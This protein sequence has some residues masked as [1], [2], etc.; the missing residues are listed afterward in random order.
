MVMA[1]ELY[2]GIAEHEFC[3]YG[4]VA[5]KKLQ[6]FVD[7]RRSMT[8]ESYR[9]F[10]EHAYRQFLDHEAFQH[11]T[12]SGAKARVIGTNI[13][14]CSNKL[15]GYVWYHHGGISRRIPKDVAQGAN[16]ILDDEEDEQMA[17]EQ[18]DVKVP[19]EM[20]ALDI[21]ISI[22]SEE[23]ARVE[24][25][26][27]DPFN[28]M[29]VDYDPDDVTD[30]YSV[31]PETAEVTSD[32]SK[33]ATSATHTGT[34][35]Q[36]TL[37]S[38]TTPQPSDEPIYKGIQDMEKEK[39]KSISMETEDDLLVDV[40]IQ[41]FNMLS[42]NQKSRVKKTMEVKV[43]LLE[44][45]SLQQE[46]SKQ[47]NLFVPPPEPKQEEAKESS[48]KGEE[49]KASSSKGEEAKESVEFYKDYNITGNEHGSVLRK[50][51][52]LCSP[53]TCN[54]WCGFYNQGFP[55]YPEHKHMFWHK[56]YRSI[57]PHRTPHKHHWHTETEEFLLEQY[58][59]THQGEHL[60]ST[61]P[62]LA[63]LLKYGCSDPRL[64][65]R[66][67]KEVTRRTVTARKKLEDD[68]QF[69]C[70]I[71][72][73]HLREN[74]KISYAAVCM[75]L[76]GAYLGAGVM[77]DRDPIYPGRSSRQLSVSF[78]NLG[79][80]CRKIFERL[81]LPPQLEK[82]RNYMDSEIDENF[83][84]IGEKP[85]YNNF[86]INVV[87][88]LG[89][90]IFLNCEA[91]SIY[92]YGERLIEG[93]YALCFN[94]WKNLMRAAR[95]GKDRYV[96]QIAGYKE[97]EKDT[98]R[99]Y[100]SWAIFEVCFGKTLDRA[101]EEQPL[102]RGKL[103]V[104]RVCVYHVDNNASADATSMTGEVIAH[105]AWEC[106]VFQ[107]D[108][109]AGDGNKACYHL[110]PKRSKNHMP[111]YESN[112]IQFWIDRMM[113]IATQSRNKH[114]E[115]NSAPVRVKHFISASYEDLQFLSEKLKGKTLGAYTG[116]LVKA[117][118]GKGDCC[119]MSIVEWGHTKQSLKEDL[120]FFEDEEHRD[121]VGE[122][123]FSV[124]ETCL[125]ADHNVFNLAPTGTDAHNLL[126]VHL[127]PSDMSN[128]EAQSY[129]SSQSKLTK[130][131][132]RKERQVEKKK[133]G[134]EEEEQD[135]QE[136]HQPWQGRW[137]ESYRGTSSSSSYWQRR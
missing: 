42:S 137:N 12:K 24:A 52:G 112:L 118:E 47:R 133:R 48:S 80:W 103:E 85:Q 13:H 71:I 38:K 95:I 87:K 129:K 93:G 7:Q 102:T 30:A 55:C 122:F 94:D 84:R 130:S 20:P 124:N 23:R 76:A 34:K 19:E 90:H 101:E 28:P 113:H 98:N 10:V 14:I 53:P 49:S 25:P 89:T 108:V 97:H 32:A 62:S 91:S 131:Q 128:A 77:I 104:V 127:N 6:T 17:D 134:R 116:K 135:Y 36:K 69:V 111:T 51:E 92:P 27:D 57:D 82:Y 72:D 99:R 8:R 109:I 58:L 123:Y 1:V 68:F 107:V 45:S 126:V 74:D 3:K 41:W 70:G 83:E 114:Y 35:F 115:R 63:K 54:K 60:T 65:Q 9:F 136:W 50:L 64:H 86:F 132:R 33:T 59:E 21:K 16:I 96:H 29:G 73:E 79:N 66:Y 121:F 120:K 88:N 5:W 81:P 18:G 15:E 117:T 22:S 4:K 75:I 125:L 106:M 61:I 11:T 2:Q 105:M 46:E 40:A 100:V 39:K 43:E 110:H 56:K 67:E 78:W 37:V 119:M 31:Q 26:Q 44:E